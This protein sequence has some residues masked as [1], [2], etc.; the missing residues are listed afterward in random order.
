MA[1][2]WVQQ[3]SYDSV[4]WL[5]NMS[6]I[7]RGIEFEFRC[8]PLP[9]CDYQCQGCTKPCLALTSLVTLGGCTVLHS[10]LSELKL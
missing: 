7:A 8:S 6:F 3:F 1:T 4:T 9:L 2:S 5:S 10:Y